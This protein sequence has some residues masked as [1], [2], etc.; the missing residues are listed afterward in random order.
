[1]KWFKQIFI[2]I[3]TLLFITLLSACGDGL[4]TVPSEKTT[5]TIGLTDAPIDDAKEV[6]I[7][8]TKIEISKDGSGWENY[9]KETDEVPAEKVNLLDFSDGEVFKFDTKEFDSGQYGQIRLFLSEEPTDNTII[10]A[11]NETE[12]LNLDINAGIRNN[13]LKIVSNFEIKEGVETELTID[14]DVRKS[15]V[16]KNPN[17][18]P[19]V[20]SLKPTIKLITNDVSG[21]IVFT[22]NAVTMSAGDVFFLYDSGFDV[23]SEL[24]EKFTA[25]SVVEEVAYEN[26]KSSA[27]AFIDEADSEL[28]ITFSFMEYDFYD[29][30]K[31]E[32]LG[33]D[34]EALS[35]V[36]GQTGIELSA[37]DNGEL[38][39]SE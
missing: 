17:A 21:N 10:L 7:T 28:K 11:G 18:A 20:Y 23:T 25:D 26:S 5:L 30:Y 22:D 13:G 8:I 3:S 16:V 4:F 6:N 2:Y 19:P 31:L 36:P 1:M 15:I 32:N 24:T 9:Y 35:V 27:I 39:I 33:T 14:F 12:V 38:I 34:A 37:D 29:L